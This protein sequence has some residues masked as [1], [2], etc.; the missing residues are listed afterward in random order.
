MLSLSK[1]S[2][3]FRSKFPSGTASPAGREEEVVIGRLGGGFREKQLPPLFHHSW[4]R[5]AGGTE[6]NREC[7]R[8]FS[9]GVLQ[10]WYHLFM[11]V[12]VLLIGHF[13]PDKGLKAAHGIEKN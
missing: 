12:F 7:S 6:S 3:S 8:W 9:G 1:E 5:T 2:S 13:S 4:H 11:Y 10:D